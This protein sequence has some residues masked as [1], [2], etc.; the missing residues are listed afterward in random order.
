MK[1]FESSR[2]LFEVTECDDLQILQA[3]IFL[4][5]FLEVSGRLSAAYSY[6][7]VASAAALNM[8]VHRAATP[9]SIDYVTLEIRKRT[10]WCLWVMDSYLTAML[11]LPR[12][13]P[14]QCFDQLLPLE[15]ADE[16]ISSPG[17]WQESLPKDPAMILVTSHI[18]LMQI[19]SEIV[20]LLYPIR[21]LQLQREKEYLHVEPS[22]ID[23]IEKALDDW[24][25]QLPSGGDAEGFVAPSQVRFV[26]TSS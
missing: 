12:T 5:M 11:G 26:I 2:A 15:R 9:A 3:I 23:R 25:H 17:P 8:G 22:T 6:L 24:F 1:Y 7:S 16:Q 14:G 18:K 21:N 13:I 19:M 10:F 4:I 20:D